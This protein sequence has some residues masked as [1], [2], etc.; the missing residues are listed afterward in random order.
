MAKSFAR[1]HRDNLVNNGIL[2]LIFDNASDYDTIDLNDTLVINNAIESVKEGKV[3]VSNKTK[4]LTYSLSLTVTD[5]Q[6]DM[7]MAGGLL[8]MIREKNNK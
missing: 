1:I 4:S 3:I 7:L 8:N 6:K 5:R 2:P